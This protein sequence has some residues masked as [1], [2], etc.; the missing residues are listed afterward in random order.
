MDDFVLE[1]I[2]FSLRSFQKGLPGYPKQCARFPPE[3]SRFG[4]FP[5]PGER[6]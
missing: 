1:S 6:S 4:N 3:S 2:A 5:A